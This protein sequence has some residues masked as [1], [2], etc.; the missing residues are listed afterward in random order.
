[1]KKVNKDTT[2]EKVLKIKDSK[3]VLAKY[4]VP[5]LSCPFAKLEMGQLTIGNICKNYNIKKKDL[6]KELNQLLKE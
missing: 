4:K 5:C 3:K 1:M 6:I 2:L